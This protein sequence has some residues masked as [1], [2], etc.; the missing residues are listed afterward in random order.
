MFGFSLIEL[1]EICSLVAWINILLLLKLAVWRLRCFMQN[2]TISVWLSKWKY[3]KMIHHFWWNYHSFLSCLCWI[4]LNTLVNAHLAAIYL[5]C[6]FPFEIDEKLKPLPCIT[7]TR[8][9]Y[10]FQKVMSKI[11]LCNQMRCLGLFLILSLTDNNGISSIFKLFR[12]FNSSGHIQNN[13]ITN[14]KFEFDLKF[15]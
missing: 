1:S 12:Q 13:S 8:N 7:S 5:K 9:I 2:T 14:E 3:I 6:K 11:H 10:S 4:P 15:V